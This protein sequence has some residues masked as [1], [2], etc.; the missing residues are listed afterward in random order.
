MADIIV[1]LRADMPDPQRQS[2]LGALE[3]LNLAFFMVSRP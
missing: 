1:R 2:K 3:G